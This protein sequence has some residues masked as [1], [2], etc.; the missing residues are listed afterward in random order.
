F[1]TQCTLVG[2]LPTALLALSHLKNL[3]YRHPYTPL[4]PDCM[5]LST[6]SHGDFEGLGNLQQLTRL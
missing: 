1:I 5:D 6:A 4:L 2:P 3:D